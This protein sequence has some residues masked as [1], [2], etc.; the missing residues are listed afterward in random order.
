MVPGLLSVLAILIFV[1]EHREQPRASAFRLSLPASPA[2]RWLLVGSVLFAVGNSSDMF[3]LLKAQDVGMTTTAV[4]LLYVLYNVTYSAASLPLGGLS[5]R[6]GQYPLV[7]AGYGVFAIVYLGFSA[8]G[9]GL[10]LAGLFAAYGIYIAATEG[11]S[12]ALIGR[13]I[14]T[15][16]RASALGLYYTAT[17][18]ASFAASTLGGLLWSAV[19]P[20]A[21]FA[22][23]AAAAVAAAALMLLGRRRVRQD[24]AA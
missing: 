24:L 19:G 23:G 17:G 4:I 6:V 8:A 22:Y 18:L 9:S 10:E 13:A 15:G 12:K 16:E 20:W 21:T 11:T 3:I 1:R 5:D 14:P 7:I 2:F